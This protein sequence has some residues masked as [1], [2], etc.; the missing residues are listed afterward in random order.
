MLYSIGLLATA[1]ILLGLTMHQR[2]LL[3]RAHA[4]AGWE[5]RDTDLGVRLGVI[6]RCVKLV[7]ISFPGT[8]FGH[9]LLRSL[10]HVVHTTSAWQTF[11]TLW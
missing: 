2:E 7:S 5:A 1:A 4:S 10:W 6:D 8:I 11:R 9:L 3:R